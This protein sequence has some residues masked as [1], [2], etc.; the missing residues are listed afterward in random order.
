MQGLIDK[1][2]DHLSIDRIKLLIES[3]FD[4][5]ETITFLKG[6]ELVELKYTPEECI[7]IMVAINA[8]AKQLNEKEIFN[9]E[10]MQ[11]VLAAAKEKEK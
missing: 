2:C 10:A 8:H 6:S 7:V 4:D 11:Q 5:W 3:G 1:L 9:E